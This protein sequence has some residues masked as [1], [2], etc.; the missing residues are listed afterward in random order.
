MICRL[1]LANINLNLLMCCVQ[2]VAFSTI[3][4]AGKA[5]LPEICVV[6]ETFQQRL[7]ALSEDTDSSL[8]TIVGPNVNYSGPLQ[9]IALPP[10]AVMAGSVVG[11]YNLAYCISFR[12]IERPSLKQWFWILLDHCSALLERR[13]HV[14][15]WR[16]N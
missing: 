3:V 16:N 14:I 4:G 6:A 12:R 8:S 10:C 2:D 15:T 9:H 13:I 1:R 11:W 5:T 7:P